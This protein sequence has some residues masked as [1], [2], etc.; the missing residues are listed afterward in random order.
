MN[1]EPR[2]ICEPIN[3]HSD[4]AS[5]QPTWQLGIIVYPIKPNSRKK[6]PCNVKYHCCLQFIPSLLT[7]MEVLEAK[8]PPRGQCTSERKCGRGIWWGGGAARLRKTSSSRSLDC[9]Q[10]H[11]NVCKAKIFA[12][13]VRT[14]VWSQVEQHTPQSLE[15][16][17]GKD[18]QILG[19]PWLVSLA[20]SVIP[21]LNYQG[22]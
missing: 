18:R 9:L 21:K 17:G 20:Q 2:C 22:R 8:I 7:Y 15:G 19:V 4:K 13:V 1:V 14:I 5:Y 10:N 3:T 11:D 6:L 12:K 16:V